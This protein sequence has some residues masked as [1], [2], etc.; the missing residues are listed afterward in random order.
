MENK[1]LNLMF[2]IALFYSTKRGPAH[3]Y[4]KERCKEIVNYFR[5]QPSFIGP[6]RNQYGVDDY[7]ELYP[8]SNLVYELTQTI[9]SQDSKSIPN[10]LWRYTTGLTKMVWESRKSNR[11]KFRIAITVINLLA[12]DWQNFT[13]E[14]VGEDFPQLQEALEK[15]QNT[16]S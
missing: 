10:K 4:V 14:E 16:G 1:T 15:L 13:A 8:K 6:Y 12:E 5:T 7:S 2:K 9:N 11:A 3:D